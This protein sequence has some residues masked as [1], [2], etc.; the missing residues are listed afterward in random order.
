LAT[1]PKGERGG[2]CTAMDGGGVVA[3]VRDGWDEGGGGA[4]LDRPG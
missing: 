1:P 2:A 4:R 3:K